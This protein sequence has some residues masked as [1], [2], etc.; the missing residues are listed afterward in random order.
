MNEII[1][2]SRGSALALT[3]TNWVAD[4]IRR[5]NPSIET[6]VEVIKTSGD[7]I[8]DTPLSKIGDK[9]LFVKELEIAL[10]ESKIDIAVHSMKDLPT[11]TPDGLCIAAVPERAEQC[12]VLVSAGPGLDDLPTGARIGSGS[13]RR[14]AQIANHRPD[15]Q[16]LELR[17]NLDT[18]L[19]K[20]DSGE[21][22]AVILACAG[23]RRL[24]LGDRVSQKLPFEICV[25]AVGQG[26]LAIEARADDER[27]RR[28]LAPLE[29]GNAR[30]EVAAE[31]ALMAALEGGCQTPIGGAAAIEDGRLRLRAM[32]A[33]IDGKTIIRKDATSS[34]DAPEELGR[35]VA[36][37]LLRSGAG[38]ILENARKMATGQVGAA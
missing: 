6:R 14:R 7:K 18:R 11:D 9:G 13:L 19:R 4:Q 21:Y 34:P 3:Q 2:G 24:G 29:D 38:E 25:P 33:S 22:D 31:R 20:L 16:M 1:I 36:Y 17:G 27:V 32:V 15:L 26:A 23:L 30:A 37:A 8:L 10:L 28:I 35:S 5:H 12:D